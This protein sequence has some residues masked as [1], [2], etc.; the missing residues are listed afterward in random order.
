MDDR[1]YFTTPRDIQDDPI[2]SNPRLF[3]VYMWCRMR[4]NYLKK[5]E[6]RREVIVGNQS[7]WIERNQ[8]V[9]GTFKAEAALGMKKSTIWRYLR[10]LEKRQKLGIK[11]TNKYSII[12]VLCDL[13]NAPRWETNG[14]QMGTEKTKNKRLT[15]R[16][17]STK[18]S[19]EREGEIEIDRDHMNFVKDIEILSKEK[20]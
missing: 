4:A 3:K 19:K 11:T 6:E 7:V 14:K 9:F 10:I 17:E 2:F 12:T 13:L 8:F 20:D 16:E 15:R 1:G 5:G 18:V